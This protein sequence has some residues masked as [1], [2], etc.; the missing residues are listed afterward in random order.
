MKINLL[1]FTLLLTSTAVL[2]E[3]SKNKHK[4]TIIALSPHIVEMLFDVGAGEQIIGTTD[5]ADFPEQ[6]KKIPRIGARTPGH[7]AH[8]R[9]FID[10]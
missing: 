4:P 5:F 6:A 2:A 8:Q 1:F 9:K 10:T 7:D 3:T